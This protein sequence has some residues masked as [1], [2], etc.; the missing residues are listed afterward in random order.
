M[1]GLDGLCA[2]N[3]LGL[4]LTDATSTLHVD[5]QWLGGGGDRWSMVKVKSCDNSGNLHNLH[6]V[7]AASHTMQLRILVTATRPLQTI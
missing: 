7:I 2:L 6:T 3:P 5:V 1:P 4:P